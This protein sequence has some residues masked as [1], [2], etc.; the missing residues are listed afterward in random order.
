[1]K[2]YVRRVKMVA[3]R[4]KKVISVGNTVTKEGFVH[5]QETNSS[6]H[7]PDNDDEMIV[8]IISV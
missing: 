8:S 7:S 4:T 1:M 6:T 3:K 2:P 5:Q